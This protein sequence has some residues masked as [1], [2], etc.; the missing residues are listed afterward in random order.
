MLEARPPTIGDR[1]DIVRGALDARLHPQVPGRPER[2][3]RRPQRAHLVAGPAILGGVAAWMSWIAL[4]PLRDV[5]PGRRPTRLGEA[6]DRS[7]APLATSLSSSAAHVGLVVAGRPSPAPPSAPVA[8][9]PIVA[10]LVL[11]PSAVGSWLPLSPSWRRRR[12]SPLAGRTVPRARLVGPAA[13]TLTASVMLLASCRSLGSAGLLVGGSRSGSPGSPWW[14]LFARRGVRHGAPPDAPDDDDGRASRARPSSGRHGPGAAGRARPPGRRAVAAAAAAP[15]PSAR[16]SA[17]G[18]SRWPAG[19]SASR[20]RRSPA[21]R[22]GSASGRSPTC[23]RQPRSA[24]PRRLPGLRPGGARLRDHRRP[25]A[26]RLAARRRRDRRRLAAQRPGPVAALPA[27]GLSAE[28]VHRGLLVP[29]PVP[30]VALRPARD[31]GRRRAFGPAPRGM[32]RYAIEVD[33]DGVLTI[34]TT[35]ITLGPLPVALGQ[36]GI[37]PPRVENG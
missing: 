35:Q 22:R 26:R 36:P 18:S 32:D 17:S 9:D 13:A 3:R 6:V 24:D 11:R 34:D 19:R 1:L 15:A 16:R 27:P 28:P 8:C 31:Q 21:A 5:R 29:L 10:V 20:G 2:P 30:P 4:V 12:P 14:D 33:G 25:G 7:A 37:I 23:R